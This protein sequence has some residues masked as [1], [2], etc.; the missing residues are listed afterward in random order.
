M[1][2]D[3]SNAEKIA[4]LRRE[5]SEIGEEIDRT[6]ATDHDHREWLRELRTSIRL[7]MVKLQGVLQES[8]GG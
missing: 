5:L 4:S 7:E 2:V 3:E 1:A 8:S 6:P